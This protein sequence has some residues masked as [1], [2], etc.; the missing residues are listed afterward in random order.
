M[1][2]QANIQSIIDK[3]VCDLKHLIEINNG[4]TLKRLNQMSSKIS[5]V[6][7]SIDYLCNEMNLIKHSINSKYSSIVKY[8]KQDKNLNINTL[9]N[10][11]N[12]ENEMS[13]TKWNINATEFVSSPDRTDKMETDTLED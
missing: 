7:H 10:K 1:L 8:Y 4:Q 3:I 9:I 12:V 5:R 13:D 6:S 2:S 11:Q